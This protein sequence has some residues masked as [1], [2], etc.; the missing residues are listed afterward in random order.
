MNCYINQSFASPPPKKKVGNKLKYS[1]EMLNKESRL[2]SSLNPKR[3]IKMLKVKMATGAIVVF[4]YCV[5]GDLI[6]IYLFPYLKWW[7]MALLAN[8]SK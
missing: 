8:I 6:R 7:G 1:W 2:K 4:A 5:L 3:P